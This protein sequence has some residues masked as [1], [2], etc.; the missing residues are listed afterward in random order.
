MAT[1]RAD[2]DRRKTILKAIET[3]LEA[4]TYWGKCMA[5]PSQVRAAAKKIMQIEKLA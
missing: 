3:Q 1:L 5:R 2:R 4:R